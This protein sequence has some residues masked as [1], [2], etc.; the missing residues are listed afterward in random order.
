[1]ERDLELL[2]AKLG[3]KA[4]IAGGAIRSIIEGTEPRDVDI[5]L[6]KKEHL[7]DVCAIVADFTG[8]AKREMTRESY[9]TIDYGMYSIVLPQVLHGRKLYGNPLNVVGDYDINVSQVWMTPQGKVKGIGNAIESIH[10]KVFSLMH[11]DNPKKLIAKRVAKYASYGYELI[12]SE[13]TFT[14]LIQEKLDAYLDYEFD[15]YTPIVMAL[16]KQYK[17]V[18]L[19]EAAQNE[20][21]LSSAPCDLVA[22]YEMEVLS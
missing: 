4:Y 3:N 1:M 5:Y 8:T 15:A 22:A 2:A 9:A 11:Y 20:I 10:N 17:G 6:T 12:G 19:S 7:G 14:S 18:G 21:L 13:N 16:L